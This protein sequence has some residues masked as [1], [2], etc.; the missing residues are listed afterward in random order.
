MMNKLFIS[1][2]LVLGLSMN[3]CAQKHPPLPPHP[4]K[5]ELVDAKMRE[6][7]KRY[8]TEKKLI[9]NHPLATKQMKRDQLK[10]LNKRYQSE[11]RLLRSLK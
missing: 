10:A 7:D 4:S 11:K 6:L 2:L 1:T 5:T 8:N 9:L 3:V